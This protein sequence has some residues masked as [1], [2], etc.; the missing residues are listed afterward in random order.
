MSMSEELEASEQTGA[1]AEFDAEFDKDTGGDAVKKD[2]ED[3]NED[4]AKKKGEEG[5]DKEK[6]KGEEGEGG[7]DP[8]EKQGGADLGKMTDD[9]YYRE[10]IQPHLPDAELT[11]RNGDKLKLSAFR[12]EWPEMSAYVEYM[13]D[14]IANAIL[15]GA[16]SNGEIAKGSEVKTL[17]EELGAKKISAQVSAKHSDA[18]TVAQSAEYK[19]WLKKQ[20]PVVKAAAESRDPADRIFCLD[21]YKQAKGAAKPKADEQRSKKKRVDALHGHSIADT[22]SARVSSAEEDDEFNEGWNM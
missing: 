18:D 19:V 13:A 12:E 9:Q 14:F 3:G 4:P 5:E 7:E 21:L 15:G 16:I 20:P 17:L 8:D 6:G 11:L 2:G 10:V 22:G 1:D